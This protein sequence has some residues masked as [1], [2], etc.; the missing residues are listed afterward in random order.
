MNNQTQIP[1][2]SYVSENDLARVIRGMITQYL[3]DKCNLQMSSKDRSGKFQ[4]LSK[5]DLICICSAFRYNPMTITEAKEYFSEAFNI[6]LLTDDEIIEAAEKLGW[7]QVAKYTF[8]K[9]VSD[10]TTETLLWSDV[11]FLVFL[12]E[13]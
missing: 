3:S 11:V 8:E 2:M 5:H 1:R 7:K 6:N 12:S 13:K 10:K 9:K 4:R